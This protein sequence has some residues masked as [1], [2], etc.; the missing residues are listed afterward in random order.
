MADRPTDPSPSATP[1]PAA[2]APAWLAPLA[3]VALALLVRWV[4]FQQ[5]HGQLLFTEPTGDAAWYVQLA[6]RIAREGFWAPRGEAYFQAPLYPWYLAL[7][8]G[9]GHLT[10]ARVLQWAGGALGALL[11]FDTARRLAGPRAG[12]VAG[13]F[14]ALYGPRLFFEGELLSSALALLFLQVALWLLV[15]DEAPP[16]PVRAGLAGLAAALAALAQPNALLVGAALVGLAAWL[17]LR[18]AAGR[19]PAWRGAALALLAAHLLLLGPVL[20]RNHAASGDWVLL[21]SNGGV[22]FFIGNN[23]DADGTFH[24]PAGEPLQNDNDGLLVSS[25]EAA[26]RAL[27]GSAGPA[28]VSGWW[29]GRGLAFWGA[30]PLA[31]VGLTAR[32]LL[33]FL[34][35]AELPNHYAIDFFRERVPILRVLPGFLL[36]MPLAL[37]GL[38]RLLRDARARALWVA[39]AAYTASVIFFFVTDRYRLPVVAMLFPAAGVGAVDLAALARRRRPGELAAAGGT[40]ALLVTLAAFRF[41]DLSPGLAHM[42][43]LLGSLYY[44]K[45]QLGLARQEF[46]EALRIKANQPEALNNLG[47]TEMLAGQ[48]TEAEAHFRQAIQ[49]EPRRPEAWLNLEELLRN[50]GAWPECLQILGQMRASVPGAAQSFGPAIAYRQGLAHQALGDTATARV[51]LTAA[52]R[53]KP[54]LAGAWAALAG[55]DRAAGRLPAARDG[56]SRAASLAPDY[57]GHPYNLGLVLEEMGDNAGALAAYRQSGRLAPNEFEPAYRAALVSDK[58]GQS[59]QAAGL[60]RALAARNFGPAFYQLG[61]L[62]ELAGQPREAMDAYRRALATHSSTKEIKLAADRLAALEGKP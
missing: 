17:A 15:R 28:A 58:L 18:D 44:R 14:A 57:F 22:N 23:A 54:D 13:L 49:V 30:R 2:G 1:A 7:V 21:S 4:Y 8:G 48:V 51:E 55:L 19:R 45:S 34:N 52:L 16:T 47:R 20:V 9:A 36:L 31:A 60:Y 39:A 61:R 46:E 42:H 10:L 27:G 40:L 43:N 3:V 35:G 53:G 38:W 56:F 33:Y 41:V 59:D 5:I 32:K 29:F 62:A 11:A 24:L 26:R 50:R 37:W 6:G 12:L 25:T